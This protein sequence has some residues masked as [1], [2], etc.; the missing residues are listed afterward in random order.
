[1]K[2]LLL[3]LILVAVAATQAHAQAFKIIVNESNTTESISKSDLSDIFLK[4]KTKWEDGSAAT[5]IDLTAQNITRI[6]FT[7][8][9][10]G[11]DVGS[12]RSYWQ[13]AAFSGAGNAPLERSADAAVIQFVKSNTGAVGYVSA[14]TETTGV[15][16]LT[17]Q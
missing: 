9:V 2:K 14:A 5:P 3:F 11:K 10:H 12:I 13:K 7:K 4:K 8:Q 6:L 1:M 17:V 16:V 15:K